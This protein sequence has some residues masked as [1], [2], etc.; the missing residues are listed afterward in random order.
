[1]NYQKIGWQGDAKFPH[2]VPIKGYK[3]IS[4]IA[5]SGES[6]IDILKSLN[7]TQ[8]IKLIRSIDF[9]P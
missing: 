7:K 9:D 5:A 8:N 2:K 3:Y 6:T 1:M 4:R